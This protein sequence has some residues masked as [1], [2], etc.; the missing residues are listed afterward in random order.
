MGSTLLCEMCCRHLTSAHQQG[1]PRPNVG[2]LRVVAT[3]PRSTLP[4]SGYR[5]S[6]LVLWH[7]G[8]VRVTQQT[9][10]G[11]GGPA[12]AIE[13]AWKPGGEAGLDPQR[14]FKGKVA[15][16]GAVRQRHPVNTGN[17]RVKP[18]RCS[19]NLASSGAQYSLR[20]VASCDI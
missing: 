14:T 18:C 17:P 7:I 12:D 2:N 1:A 16:A 9:V 6:D 13:V 5:R 15:D 8:C 3:S 4:R 10:A 19:P 20:G 11:I